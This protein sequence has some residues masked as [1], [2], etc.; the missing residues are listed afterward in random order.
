MK[1]MRRVLN[2][3]LWNRSIAP[4]YLPI[5]VKYLFVYFC[6]FIINS[7]AYSQHFT[8]KRSVEG[9]EILENGKKVLFYQVQPKSIG[10]QY[11]RAGYVH[12]L[13]SLDEAIMTEDMP[14]DHPYHRGIF[15]AWH[16]IILNDKNIADGWVSEHI[17]FN[18]KKVN[19]K[20]SKE[21]VTIQSLVLWNAELEHNKPTNIVR[22]NT[23][24]TVFQSTDTYRIL[25]FD[26]HLA[27]LVD[28]LK[29]GGSDDVKGY[30][31]FCLRL[32]LP[33]DI[34][35]ISENKTIIPKETPVMAGPWMDFTGS[36]DGGLLP[37]SG[38]VVF[39][40]SSGLKD[41]CPWILRKAKSM[42]NVPFPGRKPVPLSKKG[43]R[44]KYRV[45][46][47]KGLMKDEDI[48]KL[49]QRYIHETGKDK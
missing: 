29:I 35:F 8:T 48:D 22:E 40:Y 5:Y 3:L 41:Q 14:E 34:T 16:Q 43:I 19:V 6:L 31:G 21:T 39:G 4:H 49:Y 28:N 42:Q 17:S 36:F 9:I 20:S 47:H 24:I 25:D 44:L 33:E 23:R 38:V 45:I 46:V 2:H 37:K 10:G 32:K 1:N 11:E 12:P 15:W 13:Y 26:I 27:A 30:G 18:P 7:E